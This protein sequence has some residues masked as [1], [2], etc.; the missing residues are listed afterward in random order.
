VPSETRVAA[1]AGAP[2]ETG[3]EASSPV[4]TWN[5][6]LRLVLLSFLLLFLELALIR[7]TGENIVHLSF[8]T[9]FVL[10]G[11]FLGIGLGFLR[12]NRRLNLFPYAPIA[13][14]GLVAFI[15]FFPVELKSSTGNLIYFG[16]LQTSGP[17]REVVLGLIFIAVAAVMACVAEGVART[18]KRFEPL[19]AYRFDLLGSVL[20]IVGISVLSLLGAPSVA[21]GAVVAVVLIGLEATGRTQMWLRVLQVVALGSVLVLLT[22]ESFAT[23]ITW[24]PYYKIKTERSAS[25]GGQ[26]FVSV[27]GVPHQA[28][29]HNDQNPLYTL[30]YNPLV[31]K[32]LNNVLVIGAGGGNDVSVALARGARHVDAVEIDP[33]IQQIGKETHPDHPYN[34]PRVEVHINDGRAFLEQTNRRYDLIL[35]ALTDSITLVPGQGSVRLESFLFT[36]QAFESA[37]AHLK[38]HGVFA[39]DNFYRE[40]WLRDRLAGTLK[41]VFGQAPCIGQVGLGGTFFTVLVD[42][43]NRADIQCATVWKPAGAVPAPSTDD[44]PFPYLRTAS[45]PSLYVYTNLLILA[46]SLVLVRVVGGRLRAMGGYL[47]LFFMGVAFLLLET[48]NVVQYAL[49][50][51][52]TWFVN[53]LVFLGILLTVLFAVEVSRRVTFRRPARLYLFLLA[54]LVVAWAVPQSSLLSLPTVPRFIA[55]T[56]LAFAPVFIANLVFTQRF[57]AVSSSTTAFAAN[58]LGAMVGGLLEYAALVFGYRA[59][60]IVV[61]AAYGLAFFFGRSYLFESEASLTG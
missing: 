45:L 37:R 59:L 39:M 3:S 1:P 5:D 11:S 18:F 58:L 51:G 42:A 34:D 23:G 53:A 10:L 32:Q 15:R 7:W 41:Q 47:D 20:G 44:H 48:K 56:A 25:A 9:N 31:H 19:E 22:F 13:L 43:P 49:L 57:K 24:S 36:K 29:L 28:N 26:A 6:R 54:S 35:L 55:A 21:W 4:P 33:Q 46:V 60:L 30:V 14:A 40:T 50:F 2:P 16:P 17:P 52:T 27:N 38:P 8:F 61:A 12:A